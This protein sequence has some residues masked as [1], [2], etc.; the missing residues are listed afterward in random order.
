MAVKYSPRLGLRRGIWRAGSESTNYT[1]LCNR[2][3][4]RHWDLH[5]AGSFWVGVSDERVHGSVELRR[6][7]SHQWCRVAEERSSISFDIYVSF[8]TFL[9]S[10]HS[11]HLWLWL[12]IPDDD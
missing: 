5:G 10:F 1:W 11:D 3:V 12:E 4:R 7:F 6:E 8:L 9:N 2:G